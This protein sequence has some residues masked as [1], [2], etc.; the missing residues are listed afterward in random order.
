MHHRG[1]PR[2]SCARCCHAPSV[3]RCSRTWPA[4]SRRVAPRGRSRRDGG[5]GSRCS[6]RY[7]RCSAAAGGAAG[8]D[9]SRAPM[10]CVPVDRRSN[11]GSPT[12]GMPPGGSC[13]GRCT[14]RSRW[15]R[16]PSAS[17][18][19][20]RCG[21]SPARCCSIRCRTP[22][23]NRSSTSGITS[24]GHRKNSR[25][26]APGF[27]HSPAWRNMRMAMRRS[28]GRMHRHASCP[29]SPRRRRFSRCSARTPRSGAALPAATT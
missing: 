3:P 25:G 6:P 18:E 10:R 7:P 8:G 22:T 1:W 19:S 26:C 23:R 12:V 15:S 4:S 27:L 28:S 2:R 29:W 16:W 11:S 21:A 14:A 20:R 13:A 17:G 24:A 5:T 9:S